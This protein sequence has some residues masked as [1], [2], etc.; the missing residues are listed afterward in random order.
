MVIWP[1]V[2]YPWR[3]TRRNIL[4]HSNRPINY[5]LGYRCHRQHLQLH[6]SRTFHFVSVPG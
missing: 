1:F 5:N 4:H 6:K 3:I 2:L